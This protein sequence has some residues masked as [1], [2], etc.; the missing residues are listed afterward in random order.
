MV[1][2]F[3]LFIRSNNLYYIQV[4]Y[5]IFLQCTVFFIKLIEYTIFFMYDVFPHLWN[6]FLLTMNA[7]PPQTT[8]TKIIHAVL[9]S[10]ATHSFESISTHSIA[11]DLWIS[12]GLLTYH[13][14][15][16]DD[17]WYGTIDYL[18]TLF[19]ESIAPFFTSKKKLPAKKLI[20]KILHVFIN[21]SSKHPSFIKL[22]TE[23]G[24]INNKKTQR[25]IDTYLQEKYMLF[26]E[27]MPHI[28]QEQIPYAFYALL[29]SC[30]LIHTSSTQCKI[31]TDTKPLSQAAIKTHVD[32]VSRT[33]FNV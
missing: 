32:F 24:N 3:R 20:P 27:Y 1:L 14:S 19:E 15:S 26:H 9:A 7:L 5:I 18:F 29:G 21:F 17:L 30:S 22:I 11:K 25:F 12:Q 13:F 6:H 16:R 2:Y 10:L 31:L 28:P 23:D 33:F 8:R 4:Y